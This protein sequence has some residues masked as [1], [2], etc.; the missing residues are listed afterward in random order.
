MVTRNGDLMGLFRDNEWFSRA[1]K[2]SRCRRFMS[3]QAFM[4]KFIVDIYIFLLK[5]STTFYMIISGKCSDLV[6]TITRKE[7]AKFVNIYST[8]TVVICYLYFLSCNIVLIRLYGRKIVNKS[9]LIAEYTVQ[10]IPWPW[11]R[12]TF[13]T[14]VSQMWQKFIK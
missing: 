5:L 8:V 3:R 2:Y 7:R 11:T 13:Q 4:W 6:E 10:F 12:Q 1:V 14:W 9:F